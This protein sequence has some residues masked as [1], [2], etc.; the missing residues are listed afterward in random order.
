VHRLLPSVGINPIEDMLYIEECCH[1]LEESKEHLNDVYL[2]HLVRLQNLAEKIR[3][4]LVPEDG[5]D[6]PLSMYMQMLHSELRQ[7]KENLPREVAQNSKSCSCST[8][9]S[10]RYR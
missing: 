8:I 7:F 1:V 5:I 2:T 10:F 9:T 6:Q 4:I 3:T